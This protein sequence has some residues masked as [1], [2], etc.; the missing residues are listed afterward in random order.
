MNKSYYQQNQDGDMTD[1]TLMQEIAIYAQASNTTP[2][3]LIKQIQEME[4]KNQQKAIMQIRQA[5]QA[6]MQQGS[7][8]EYKGG[9]TTYS[10]G[11]WYR[12][13]GQPCYECGGKYMGGGDIP[14]YMKEDVGVYNFG[15]YFPQ[16]IMFAE[17]GININ[18]ANK[19]KFTASAKRAGMGV[20]EFA[21]HVLANKEDYSSTQVKRANFARNAAK[22]K[23]EDGGMA[24]YQYEGEV[25][26]P[27]YTESPYM[28]TMAP[29]L[30]M[31]NNPMRQYMQEGGITVGTVLEDVDDA[32]LKKL[33]DQGY[34]FE[35]ID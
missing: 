8:Q 5:V 34:K 25:N 23:H 35:I 33:A 15:G 32:M 22:W 7:P 16:N 19:G 27:S 13:G 3:K 17:G 11:V 29:S 9:G 4:P 31:D 10:A 20:Q 14:N 26:V 2:E 24:S 28:Y 12:D 6:M 30:Y 21:R 18:P 1:D